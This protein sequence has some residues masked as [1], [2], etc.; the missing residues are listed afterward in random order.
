MDRRAGR[1]LLSLGI[2]LLLV[3]LVG[4]ALATYYTDLLW[5]AGIG[6]ASLFWTRLWLLVI[7]RVATG[8]L[9]AAVVLLNL[10]FVA[11]QIGPVQ[12]RRRYGNLEIAEQIPRR[13]VVSGAL[14][15]AALA[16]WWL[17][18]I[19]FTPADTIRLAAWWRAVPWGVADPLLGRDVAFYIFTLPVLHGFLGFAALV[20]V[21]S[22]MLA[23][24]GYV[25]VGAIRWREQRLEVDLVPRRHLA[26]LAGAALVLL[27]FH[28]WLSRYG[29]LVD[30]TGYGGAFGYTDR[31]A[32]LPARGVLAGMSLLVAAAIVWSVLRRRW[33]VAAVSLAALVLTGLLLGRAYPALLQ[34]FTVQPNELSREATF[35]GWNMEYT[36]RA[37]GLDAM[38][39]TPFRYAYGGPPAW[40]EVGP[41]VER[42]GL[43]DPEPLQTALNELQSIFGYYH[44]PDVDMDRY[45]PPGAQEQVAIAVREFQVRGLPQAART[46]Q[47]LHLNPTYIAGAGAVVVPAGRPSRD[48]EPVRWMSNLHPIVRSA[49]APPAVHI[50]DPRVFFGEAPGR[51]DGPAYVIWDPVRDTIRTGLAPAGVPLTSPLRTL[52]AVIRF[53]DVNLLFSGEVGRESRI[54]FRRGL[55]ERLAEL[56]PFIL[57]DADPYPVLHDGRIVW[58]VEGYSAAAGFPLSRS[59]EVRRGAAFNY[60]RNSV[61]AAVDAVTGEVAIYVAE[62]GEPMVESYRRVFPG[63]FRDLDEVPP[64]LRGHLRYAPR[65]LQVQA[66]VLREFHLESPSAFYAGQDV[67][68]IPPASGPVRGLYRPTFVLTPLPGAATAEFLVLMPFIAKERQNMTA[69]LVGRSDGEA[70]GELVLIEL[71]RDQQIPGPG[72][73]QALIEQ[74]PVISAQLSLWRQAG[75]DV[76]LGHLRV[77]PL[78]SAFFYAEPLFLSAAGS[79]IPELRRIV[80]S[81]GRN[82]VMAPSLEEAVRGLG[83]VSGA[84]AP[85]AAGEAPEPGTTGLPAPAD[86][87]WSRRALDLLEEAERLLRQGD[88]AGFGQRWAE[89]HALLRQTTRPSP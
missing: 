57:W 54:V 59:L 68:A 55:M 50:T 67:W 79:P 64:A 76:Q 56:A 27:A 77:V 3:L 12:V 18:A 85:V 32:R 19:A 2:A 38:V 13:L 39:R 44:F 69:L 80:V 48:G 25:L 61:K 51:L 35:I 33:L 60:V 4:R 83:G 30:G 74:D 82:V 63:L 31:H 26:G 41:R 81:D 29:L 86:G 7:V 37:Y 34:R 62:R 46:W 75:S 84:P 45:G 21:W 47:T 14:I 71:P 15:V 52:A 65:L 9:A 22:A 8:L 1:L 11:R 70:L 40:D 10:W 43:W 16:G 28:F 5:Y 23:I 88:W 78:D 53:G 89:L 49:D 66:E 58:I 6:Q 73:V 72:Q 17:S 36:R 87:E 24:L 20:L 42:L